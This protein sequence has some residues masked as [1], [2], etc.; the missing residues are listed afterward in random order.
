MVAEGTCH[1]LSV[2]TFEVPLVCKTVFV[3]RQLHNVLPAACSVIV[4][5]LVLSSQQLDP[6]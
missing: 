3:L 1:L 6:S 5:G 2:D 4:D